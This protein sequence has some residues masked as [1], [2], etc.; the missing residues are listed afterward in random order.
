MPESVNPDK[1]IWTHNPEDAMCYLDII[2][3]LIYYYGLMC[4]KEKSDYSY[5]NALDYLDKIGVFSK[6]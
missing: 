5:L 1:Y 6:R 4:I 2:R 3:E